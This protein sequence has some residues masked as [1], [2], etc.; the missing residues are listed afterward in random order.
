MAYGSGLSGSFGVGQ[1]STWGTSVT[2]TLWYEFNSESLGLEKNIVQGSG[3]RAGTGSRYA[4]STRRAY[5]TRTAGG[6]VE[7]DIPTKKAGLLFRHMLGSPVTTA[8][9]QAA[10]AAYKQDHRPGS[11]TGMSLTLEKGVPQT[12]GT[13]QNFLYP[14]AKI[15]DWEISCAV[16]EIAT[17]SL[18]FDAKDEV[19]TG[20]LT[21]P[22]Y[23]ASNGVFHFAQG[24]LKLGGTPS[25]TS[26]VTSISGGTTIAQV[27]AANLSGTTPLATDR[28]YFGSA[29]A[30]AEQI[31]NDWGSV[32]GSLDAEFVNQAT[33]YDLYAADTS[34]AL[35]LTF[36]G[37]NIAST[38]YYTLDI[39]CPVIFFDGE[40]PKVGGPDIVGLS[41][42]FTVLDNG[43]DNA[44]QLSYTS[45]DTALTS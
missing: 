6:T 17:M 30:K 37:A 35:E 1:E 19:T 36:V 42:D 34:T 41:A 26:N 32:T 39:V 43:T 40:T 5:T 12:D 28:Y 15:T 2:P 16:G 13:V 7:M 27:T 18:T 31:E 21:T 8:T 45:T 38:Y 9:Q 44:I 25:T 24:T 3:L 4:R 14:G 23:T 29:G 11:L 20:S 33:I 22:S 10:T